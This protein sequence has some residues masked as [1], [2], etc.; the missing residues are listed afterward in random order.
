VILLGDS[1]HDAAGAS[2]LA[3]EDAAQLRRL[4][5][6][7]EVVW[8]LGNHDPTPPADLPGAAVESLADGPLR[9]R[10]IGGAPLARG[11][12]AEI[13]GHFHP[14]ATLSTRAGAVTRACFVGDG[15]RL[16]L[17]ALGAYAGG[18]DLADAAFAPLFPRGARAFLLGQERLHS[19]PAMP[20]RGALSA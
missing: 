6:G 13:S 16:V 20:H 11:G 14:K 4:L 19:V 17:P 3:P 18:L 1:F 8:V 9:F 2:R 5:T 15:R 10:H 7:R 12:E